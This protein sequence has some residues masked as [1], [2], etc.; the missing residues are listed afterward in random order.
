MTFD[1][2]ST[3]QLALVLYEWSDVKY[4]GADSPGDDSMPVRS[5]L[6][7][8]NNLSP[9]AFLLPQLENVYMHNVRHSVRIVHEGFARIIRHY[10]SRRR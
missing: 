8:L 10:P 2:T 9:E 4:L 7:A 5:A 6:R 3:G 1:P